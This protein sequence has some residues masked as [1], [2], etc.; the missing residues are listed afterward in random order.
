LRKIIGETINFSKIQRDGVTSDGSIVHPLNLEVKKEMGVSGD[1]FMQNAQ[2]FVCFGL[3]KDL[4]ACRPCFLIELVGPNICVS[5]M[6]VA[7]DYFVCDKLTPMLSLV[8]TGVRS[9]FTQLCSLFSALARALEEIWNFYD[10]NMHKTVVKCDVLSPFY[11]E[12]LGL[13]NPTPLVRYVF[14]ATKDSKPVVV[15]FTETYCEELH[16]SSRP[17]WYGSKDSAG[18]RGCSELENHC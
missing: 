2:Y 7:E 12:Q 6:L 11:F 13:T 5:G 9:E 18:F 16:S 4:P 15:K 14:L 10:R 3:D 1:S 17:K 8:R